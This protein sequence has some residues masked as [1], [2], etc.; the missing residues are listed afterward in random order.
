MQ[1]NIRPS[2]R[3]WICKCLYCHQYHSTGIGTKI[4]SSTNIDI[5]ISISNF[6]GKNGMS[7]L[8]HAMNNGNTS[9]YIVISIGTKIKRSHYWSWCWHWYDLISGFICGIDVD[10][11][12]HVNTSI[13][14]HTGM[15]VNIN[16][17]T[18]TSICVRI[19][20]ANSFGTNMCMICNTSVDINVNVGLCKNKG[21]STRSIRA[22]IQKQ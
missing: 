19:S 21:N 4:C 14:I 1:V 3:N 2:T 16:S 11:A 7:N 22:R 8:G 12:M 10:I 5:G 20:I 13:Y 9:D 15:L 18:D 6:I 17:C